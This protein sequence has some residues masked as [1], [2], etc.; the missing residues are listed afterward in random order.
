MHTRIQ[1]FISD[2]LVG[3]LR[4]LVQ[5]AVQTVQLRNIHHVTR[6]VQPGL[7]AFD[8]RQLLGQV[9]RLLLV[10]RQL[11]GDGI[12]GQQAWQPVGD[13][14]SALTVATHVAVGGPSAGEQPSRQVQ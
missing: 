14:R 13:L 3:Q 1:R 8:T 12:F 4:Q 7:D 2:R 9:F 6:M 5:F 11:Q 10:A